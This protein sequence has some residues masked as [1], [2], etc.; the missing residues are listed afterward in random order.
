MQFIAVVI[1]AW[2]VV[3]R[4]LQ[5][6]IRSCL[7]S[8]PLFCPSM[9]VLVCDPLALFCRCWLNIS[10]KTVC[11]PAIQHLGSSPYLLNF[12]FQWLTAP[13][14]FTHFFNKYLCWHF[15]Y[16]CTHVHYVHY[17]APTG[18]GVGSIAQNQVHS[19]TVVN[20]LICAQ[21]GKSL[22]HAASS[23]LPPQ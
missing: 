22:W 20:A 12:F 3:V 1:A 18:N 15:T 23:A 8:A 7:C 11:F 4:V 21:P 14:K 19:C 17:F 2:N 16:S 10:L 5:T 13:A 6:P 9:H